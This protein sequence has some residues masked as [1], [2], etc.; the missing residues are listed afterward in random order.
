MWSAGS[1][2]GTSLDGVLHPG[3]MR[4]R[5][6]R[7]I[8][9]GGWFLAQR[10]GVRPVGWGDLSL[11]DLEAVAA[12]VHS[13]ETFVVVPERRRDDVR[14]PGPEEEPVRVDVDA[15]VTHAVY[16]VTTGTVWAV[17]HFAEANRRGA[18]WIRPGYRV[19]RSGS[20][21]RAAPR[22]LMALAPADLRRRLTADDNPSGTPG[23]ASGSDATNDSTCPTADVVG[24]PVVTADRGRSCQHPSGCA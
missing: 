17:D 13:D 23:F 22:R 10:P 14:S 4:Y 21:V 2:E 3:M 6:D 8:K 20:I 9:N 1:P 16:A 15:L 11:G 12:H 5:W 18:I 19:T 24:E 7:P